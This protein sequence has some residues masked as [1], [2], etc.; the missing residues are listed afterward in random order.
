M[1][2]PSKPG[3]VSFYNV[4]EACLII[5]ITSLA[6]FVLNMLALILTAE[7]G[8][9][10][11][12]VNFLDQLGNRSIAPLFGFALI[13][14]SFSG[15]YTLRK[16]LAFVCLMA[17]ILFQMGCFLVIHDTLA[18]QRQ[19]SAHIAQQ[20]EQFISQI[21]EGQIEVDDA[22]EAEQAVERVA[23]T[24]QELSEQAKSDI[25]RAGIVSVG[26]LLIPGLGLIGLG[27]LGLRIR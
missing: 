26:N 22:T 20:A 19:A 25:T 7:P 13:I 10:E 18:I 9:V 27:R 16:W 21:E 23:I 4:R 15:N 3:G 2:Y 12:R 24:E 8:S 17:G 6:I 14:Y 1:Q 11:W 5:G